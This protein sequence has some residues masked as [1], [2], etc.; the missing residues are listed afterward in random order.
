ML[1]P[2]SVLRDILSKNIKERLLVR[3]REPWDT[4]PDAVPGQ[5]INPGHRVT[6]LV[7]HNLHITLRR[8]K[9]NEK[10]LNDGY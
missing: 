5:Y 3:W 9:G 8:Q 2:N 7:N 10:N 1:I 6:Q 4:V